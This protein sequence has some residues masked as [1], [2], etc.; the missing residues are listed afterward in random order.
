MN[1]IKIISILSIVI[2]LFTSCS[3]DDYKLSSKSIDPFIRFNVLVNSNN[4]PLEY[5]AVN[6]ILLPANSY[7]NKSIKT[8]KVPVALTSSTLKSPVIATF[9]AVTSG[10]VNS[11]SV[12]PASELLFQGNKL[13]DTIFLSFDKRWEDKQTITLKLENTSDP[14]IHIGNLNSAAVN[15]TF[16]INLSEISTTYTFPINQIT[17]KGEVGEKID[18]KVNFPNGF[19]PSEIENNSIFK[20]LNGFDYSLTHDD[21]GDNR[22]YIT[23]HLTLLE[24]IQND[25]VRYQTNISLTNTPN[26][27]ATGN[28]VLQIAKPI[29]SPRDIETNPASKF[30]DLSNKYYLTYG[31]NWFDKSGTCAWQAYNAFTFPVV[32]TKDAENAILYSDN[33]TTNPNDDIYHDAF[34]IGFNVVSGTSTTNSFNLKRWFTNESTAAASSPG[35]NITSALEFFPENGTSK[36]KGSVLVIPQPITITATGTNKIGHIIDISGEGTYNEIS[37]GLFEISFELK[38]TNEELFGGT[39]SC[40]YRMYN[41]K[42]YPKLEALSESCPKEVDL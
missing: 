13:T 26:Y 20:F 29:K 35:F 11:F 36:T 19:I 4:T 6:T 16:T 15:D 8:L 17:I 23:Y 39:V 9:S 30:Y 41:N 40:Q 32:V 12:A 34:K 24:D 22:S 28:T 3:K 37:T 31:E 42:T 1:R 10:D 2:T 33:G 14:E 27:I 21:Y 25:D 18:F 5:P 38:L 7:E